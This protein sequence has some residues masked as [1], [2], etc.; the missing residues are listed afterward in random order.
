MGPAWSRD[1][2]SCAAAGVA[3]VWASHDRQVKGDDPEKRDT[4]IPQ[5]GGL[6][7]RLQPPP[8]QI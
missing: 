1:P 5:V 7:V 6:G 3:T 4:L 8:I 2:E